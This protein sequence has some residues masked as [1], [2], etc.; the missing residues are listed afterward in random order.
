MELLVE[1]FQIAFVANEEIAGV[2]GAE[3]LRNCLQG[4]FGANAGDV[5]EGDGQPAGLRWHG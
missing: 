5:A 1:G 3:L 2:I 4:D